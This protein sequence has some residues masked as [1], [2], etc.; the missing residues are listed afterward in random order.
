MTSILRGLAA[1]ITPEWM[2]PKAVEPDPR[3][4]PADKPMP[5]PTWKPEV[6]KTP[7][8]PKARQGRI[9]QGSLRDR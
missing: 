3:E 1:E 2:T 5:S 9:R 6:E 7:L 4:E 8:D